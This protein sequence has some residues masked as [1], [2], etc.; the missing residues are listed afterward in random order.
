MNTEITKYVHATY[1]NHFGV[2]KIR[3]GVEYLWGDG[4]TSTEEKKWATRRT[5]ITPAF[6]TVRIGNLENRSLGRHVDR[7]G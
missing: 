1:F 4:I 2:E 5:L 7:L 3:F 6:D